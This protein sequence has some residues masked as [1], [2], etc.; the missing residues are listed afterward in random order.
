MKLRLPPWPA[1]FAWAAFSAAAYII[2][3]GF[4]GSI[5]PEVPSPIVYPV[6]FLLWLAVA[7]FLAAPFVMM[8]LRLFPIGHRDIDA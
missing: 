7:A 3:V 1:L 4:A 6:D 8:A 5:V 2:G